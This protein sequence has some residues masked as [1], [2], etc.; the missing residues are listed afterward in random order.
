MQGYENKQWPPNFHRQESVFMVR[1]ISM[2]MV[3]T[4]RKQQ[5]GKTRGLFRKNGD[6]GLCKIFQPGQK[7]TETQ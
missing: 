3:K 4:R 6:I 7:T 5:K 1:G 2:N